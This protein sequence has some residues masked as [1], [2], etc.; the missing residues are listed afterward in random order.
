[1]SLKAV[2]SKNGMEFVKR[3]APDIMC[4]QETKCS[5]KKVPEEAKLEGYHRYF[6]SGTMIVICV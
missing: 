5:E 1:M 4:F 6:A 2:T 3:E